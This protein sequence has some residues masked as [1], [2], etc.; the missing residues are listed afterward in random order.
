MQSKD[1]HLLL[2]LNLLQLVK[3]SAPESMAMFML[4]RTV[5]LINHKS[6]LQSKNVNNFIHN[7]Y[8]LQ[9]LTTYWNYIFFNALLF[10]QPMIE[11]A[12]RMN[13]FKHPNVVRFIGLTCDILPFMILTELCED[14]PLDHYMRLCDLT[15]AQKVDILMQ[16]AVGLRYLS[17]TMQV[18]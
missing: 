10:F 5:R 3:E 8:R 9:G 17:E 12:M 11:E 18:V 4:A 14:G 13:S 6:K 16:C 1:Q 2:N 15:L 7:I